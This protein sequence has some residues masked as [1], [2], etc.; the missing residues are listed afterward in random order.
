M[1][2]KDTTLTRT[3]TG[4]N[5]NGSWIRAIVSIVAATKYF[6]ARFDNTPLSKLERT[7]MQPIFEKLLPQID[8]CV[9]R[10]IF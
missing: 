2:R 3:C 10:L 5:D 6:A 9:I 1:D 4:K 7:N 8:G